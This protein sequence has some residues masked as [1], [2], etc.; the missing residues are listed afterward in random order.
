MNMALMSA[1]HDLGLQTP[2][3]K[4]KAQI[5]EQGHLEEL[6]REILENSWNLEPNSTKPTKLHQFIYPNAASLLIKHT[7]QIVLS[8]QL[9]LA[10]FAAATHD[11]SCTLAGIDQKI[12]T[13]SNMQMQNVNIYKQ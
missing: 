10:S 12:Q 3:L 11:L 4:A 7:Q 2:G 9:L 1:P 13:W 8:E 5:N 6:G